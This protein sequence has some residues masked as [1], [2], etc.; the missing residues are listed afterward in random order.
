MGPRKTGLGVARWEI[1]CVLRCWG[2][3]ELR[4][5]PRDSAQTGSQDNGGNPVKTIGIDQTDLKSCV[6]DSQTERVV[7]T[8]DDVPVAILVGIEGLD[9]EQIQLGVSN[10][11]WELIGERRRQKTIGRAELEKRIGDGL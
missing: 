5:C 4:N 11:F 6:E 2:R 7:L 9:L 10:Q 1:S 8:R 3:R